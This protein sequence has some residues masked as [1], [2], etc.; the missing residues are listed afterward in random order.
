MTYGCADKYVQEAQYE[1]GVLFSFGHNCYELVPISMVWE[2]AEDDCMKRG[3]H[4]AHIKN[5]EEQNAIHNVLENYHS[6]HGVWIGLHDRNNE[7]SF[8]WSSGK[9][10]FTI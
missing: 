5:A 2:S 8:E 4:L 3:G 1:G 9:K 6:N 10:H 7:E